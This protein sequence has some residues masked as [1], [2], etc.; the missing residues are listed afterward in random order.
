MADYYQLMI[1][2]LTRLGKSPDEAR[3]AALYA[4]ARG[5]LVIELCRITPQLSEAEITRECLLFDEAVRKIEADL[6]HR[7]LSTAG[8]STPLPPIAQRPQQEFGEGGPS[9]RGR[10]SSLETY[11]PARI[12]HF[13]SFEPPSE[14]L[15]ESFPPCPIVT[16]LSEIEAKPDISTGEGINGYTLDKLVANFRDGALW[17]FADFEYRAC[18]K[19]LGIDRKFRG[20]VFYRA[21]DNVFL[22]RTSRPAIVAALDGRIYKIY[23][24]FLH[25]TEDDCREFLHNTINHFDAKYG[26]PSGTRDV[27]SE[28]KTIFWDKS[29]GN[30]TLETDSLW[31]RNAIIYTSSAVRATK[32]AWLGWILG[33]L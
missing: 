12:R 1:R 4:H 31:Y 25:V 23:F 17:E 6:A 21:A 27:N 8:G 33:N 10:E 20:E 19:D 14:F 15:D 26:P 18:R 28:Q 5:A 29:F 16:P 24:G 9:M 3:R 13:S 32:R 2:T 7:P 22:G 11:M 30:L